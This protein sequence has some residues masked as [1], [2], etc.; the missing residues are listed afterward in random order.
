MQDELKPDAPATTPPP[1][2]TYERPK[3]TERRKKILR[4]CDQYAKGHGWAASI[5]EIAQHCGT[6]YN[7]ALHELQELNKRGSIIFEGSRQIKVQ[8][9]P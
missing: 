9:L 8:E 4:F 6:N 7:T 1:S 5:E 2:R 3:L